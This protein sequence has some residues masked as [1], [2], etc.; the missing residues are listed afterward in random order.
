MDVFPRYLAAFWGPVLDSRFSVLGL[1]ASLAKCSAMLA[2][3]A[4]LPRA[5]DE[6]GPGIVVDTIA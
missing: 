3:C 1:L 4:L 5:Q 6:S 2:L